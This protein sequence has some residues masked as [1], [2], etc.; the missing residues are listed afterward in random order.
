[1][2][3]CVFFFLILKMYSLEIYYR[4]NPDSYVYKSIII[5]VFFFFPNKYPIILIQT[6]YS[7][8]FHVTK[9]LSKIRIIYVTSFSTI[10]LENSV[11]KFY[12]AQNKID[13]S[14]RQT[15]INSIKKP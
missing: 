5:I 7:C 6:G 9:S 14:N 11:Y 8:Y 10:V 1:M 4:W 13:I 3:V 15:K 2:S 12:Y